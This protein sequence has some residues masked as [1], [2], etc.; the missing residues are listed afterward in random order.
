[1]PWSLPT[2]TSTRPSSRRGW[3]SW[4][5]S[6][7]RSSDARSIVR[8]PGRPCDGRGRLSSTA[9][10]TSRAGGATLVKPAHQRREPAE[11]GGD[12]LGGGQELRG[13]AEAEQPGG[14]KGGRHGE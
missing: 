13:R 2:A 10:L 1:M 5:A 11:V 14:E 3:A 12:R 8:R 4:S 6:R 7:A 9:G